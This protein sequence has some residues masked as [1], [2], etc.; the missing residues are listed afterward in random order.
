[1]WG[2]FENPIEGINGIQYIPTMILLDAQK[3][4]WDFP[5]L[6]EKCE[7]LR[8]HPEYKPDY[9]IIEKKASG[10]TLAQE[11]H[12]SGFPLI[13]Y[14][15]RGKK[16]ER[17]QAAA[18][19]MRAGRVWVPEGKDWAQEVIDETC[20]F[21]SAP[22]DDLADTVSMAVLWMRD[23]GVIR[24]ESYDYDDDEDEN[25]EYGDFNATYWSTLVRGR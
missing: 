12:R 4:K 14:D 24:N 19:L 17:L 21:P 22:N 5:T 7:D 10:I 23:N 2:I 8:N 13:E 11:L 9:F 16:S 6:C 18:A 25:E 20:N 1:M 3:G 15:P